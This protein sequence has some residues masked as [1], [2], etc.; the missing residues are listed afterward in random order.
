LHAV[1]GE[2]GA[3]KSTLAKC[4]VGY[5]RADGGEIIIDGTPHPMTNP[6]EAHALGMGLV[7]QHFTLV[8]QMS[9]AENLVLGRTDLPPIIDWKAERDRIDAFQRTMPFALDPEAPAFAL[10]A[11][12][13][14]KLEILKH[15][16]L[17][18]RFLILDEPTS[19]LTPDEADLILGSL[20]RMTAQGL[21]SVVLI[22]HKIREVLSF[23]DVVTV[24]WILSTSSSYCVDE[25]ESM[26]ASPVSEGTSKNSVSPS[27]SWIVS[28]VLGEGLQ[29]PSPWA[30]T[31]E[32]TM[33]TAVL[34]S[35]STPR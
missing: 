27:L 6:Q 3:G 2:N 18:R 22:T 14:Q 9:V 16:Y 1:I 28:H 32:S 33:N 5:H 4:M 25:V 30:T 20:R 35:F 15:L 11:G 29:V 7:Y 31:P 23:A 17:G 12:E 24:L 21:L 13:K 19:V 8:P 34:L 26:L 10:A